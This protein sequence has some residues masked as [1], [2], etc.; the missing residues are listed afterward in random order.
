MCQQCLSQLFDFSED[1]RII[2]V[3]K[4]I[5][6]YNNT[7]GKECGRSDE[8][9]AERREG[10]GG[11]LVAFTYTHTHTHIA[12]QLRTCS[13]GVQQLGCC[14]TVYLSSALKTG[15]G[16]VPPLRSTYD[17]NHIFL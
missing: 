15:S 12:S 4:C 9:N 10:C 1:F 2:E 6:T 7:E 11:L 13:Q 14:E 3:E 8:H 16:P 5:L 17:M